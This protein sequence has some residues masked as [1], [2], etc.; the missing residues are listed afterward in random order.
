MNNPNTIEQLAANPVYLEG[1]CYPLEDI[2]EILD[3]QNRP[4]HATA[5][6]V[7]LHIVKQVTQNKQN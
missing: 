4:E 5:V 7:A 3:L 1:L 2:A 6:R